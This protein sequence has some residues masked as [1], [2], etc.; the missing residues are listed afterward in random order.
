MDY[1]YTLH[2]HTCQHTHTHTLP[3][4]YT[5]KYWEAVTMS[6]PPRRDAINDQIRLNYGLDVLKISWKGSDYIENQLSSKAFGECRNGLSVTVLPFNT[7]C[8]YGCHP[9]MRN[10]YYIWHKGGERNRESKRAGAERGHTWF[11]SSKWASLSEGSPK[12]KGR[13]WLRFI[14][15]KTDYS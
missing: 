14:S 3:C 1:V 6:S 15:T 13:E 4:H 8:R 11:L 7:I 5:E 9:K 2:T 10:T 12:L